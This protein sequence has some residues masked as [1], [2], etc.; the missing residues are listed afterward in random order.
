MDTT[1]SDIADVTHRSMGGRGCRT[2]P[3]DEQGERVVILGASAPLIPLVDVVSSGAVRVVPFEVPG[4][5]N[6]T[7]I[8]VSG[9][10]AI[11]V[12]PPR[13]VDALLGF[14]GDN[15]WS[16]TH[17]VDT[18]I[19]NDYVS[20]GLA[21]ARLSGGEYVA[22]AGSGVIC[23][24]RLVSDGDVIA[25]GPGT[26]TALLTPGHTPHHTS[27]QLS[28]EGDDVA[29]FTGGGLLYGG[30]GRTDL[31]GPDMAAELARAQWQSAR[32]LG[33]DVQG[34]ATV[35]PTHGFGSFC[36]VGDSAVG[37]RTL[38]GLAKSNPV[39]LE[40]REPF[41]QT[42]LDHQGPYPSY[43]QYMAAI[44]RGGTPEQDPQIPPIESLARTAQRAADGEWI[45]DL[46]HRHAFADGH[47]A[48]SLSFDASGPY[49]TYAGWL[50]PWGAPI[51]VVVPDVTTLGTAVIE[52]GRIGLDEVRSAALWRDGSMSSDDFATFRHADGRRLRSALAADPTLRVLDV[53]MPSEWGRG[54]LAGQLSI[55]IF[56]LQERVEEVR[57]WAGGREVWA[58]CASGFR[59]AVAAS[60]LTR[61]GIDAVHV[62]GSVVDS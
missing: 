7:Y 41:A 61:A 16:V 54:R 37:E 38:A 46:R 56:E 25:V 49:V 62:E 40:E 53:R 15:G 45:L 33:T 57:E 47:L 52:L 12:D 50:I 42:L 34:T 35:M 39:F 26:L 18:H 1:Y 59:S 55:P 17:I 4:L 31:F 13:D 22:P 36:T 9:N 20:G 43:F 27:Y 58:F 11:L 48:G 3:S 8:A 60:L 32:R 6:R 2:S 5:G 28:S 10:L 24:A 30:V 23:P 21:A 51:H 19:H 29:V 14:V 44:N